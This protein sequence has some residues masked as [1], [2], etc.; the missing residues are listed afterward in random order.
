[1]TYQTTQLVGIPILARLAQSPQD[2][3]HKGNQIWPCHVV[4]QE[5]VKDRQKAQVLGQSL[6]G[7]LSLLDQEGRLCLG[8]LGGLG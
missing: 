2:L 8:R 1:M 3:G 6:G 7:V 5:R 4:H